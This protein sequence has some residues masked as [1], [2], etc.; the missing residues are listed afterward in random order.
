MSALDTI[1]DDLITEVEEL[2]AKSTFPD[3]VDQSWC[4]QVVLDAYAL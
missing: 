2:A 4:D 3:K 1:L